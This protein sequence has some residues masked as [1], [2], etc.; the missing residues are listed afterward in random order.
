[1][2][3]EAM[4]AA[5]RDRL[6][7]VLRARGFRGSL[8]HYRRIR[9]TAIDLLTVQFDKWGGGFVVELGR[10]GPGGFTTA[11]GKEIPPG[12]V[13]AH[14]LNPSDRHRLGSPAP[15]TDGRWF[16]FDDGTSVEA[17]ADAVVAMLDEAE[18]WW[19]AG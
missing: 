13:T 3:R 19:A 16:R 15:G 18:S 4:N 2:N 5:L 17:A 14:D 12:Q 1:M 8:P 10:C 11:W 7:P 9:A 6:V